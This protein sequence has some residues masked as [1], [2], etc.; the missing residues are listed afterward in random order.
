MMSSSYYQCRSAAQLSTLTSRRCCPLV[1]GSKAGISEIAV[2]SWISVV[3]KTHAGAAGLI[4]CITN[5]NHLH[6]VNIGGNNI[7]DYCGFDDVAILNPEFRAPHPLEIGE[8][9]QRAVPSHDLRIRVRCLRAS[10]IHFVAR[11][12]M[13]R[14]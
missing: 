4:R 3:I 2:C 13:W 11:R 9:P 14:Q 5:L 12:A 7:A 8:T 10:K 1:R 6:S